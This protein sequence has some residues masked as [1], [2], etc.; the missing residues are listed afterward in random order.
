MLTSSSC[1]PRKIGDLETPA[2]IFDAVVVRRNIQRMADYGAQSGLSIR[3]H[4]KTHKSRLV[5]E[6]Q[7]AA[8]AIGVTAAKVGEAETLSRPGDDLLLAYPP[9]GIARATRLARLAGD[10]VVRAAVDTIAAVEEVSAAACSADV[11][12]GVMVDIDVGMGRTGVQ[13]A[14]DSFALAAAIERSPGLRLD[15]IMIYPGHVWAAGDKQ[16]GALRAIAEKIEES[17]HLWQR[18]GLQATIVSGGS[19]PTAYQSHLIPQLTEIRPGTYV[20]NDMNT[21]RGGFCSLSD[22]AARIVTTVISDAVHGQVVIDA[23][24]KTLAIDSCLPQLDSGYGHVVEYAEAR[25]TRLSEEHGQIDVRQCDRSPAVG[26]RLTVIPNH[27]CPCVNLQNGAWWRESDDIVR[28]LP[29]DARG[30][31]Q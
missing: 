27:I 8:G 25:I 7:L 11:T 19:T 22:C 17:L 12:I 21:V 26:E 13:S 28:A 9:I 16:H 23:G 24:S 31:L 29:I 3:P 6:L 10:R 15:G 5:G 20:Y 2:L 14:K 1:Q 18:H 30:M 4:Y